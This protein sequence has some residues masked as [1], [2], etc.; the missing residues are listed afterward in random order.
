MDI[1]QMGV[2]LLSKQLGSQTDANSLSNA[3]SGL[4]GDGQGNIDLAGLAGKMASSGELGN[5]LNSWLGDGANSTITAENLTN[6]LG[7]SKISEFASQVGTDSQSAAN[8]LA[9]VLPQLMD[10]S[11]SG[12]S[13]LDSVGGLDGLL[14]A[15]SSFLK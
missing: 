10:K 8:G 6:L 11:S 5:I 3:L 15:A 12:G 9:D 7:D 4:L 14:G 2:D 13:L 1:V